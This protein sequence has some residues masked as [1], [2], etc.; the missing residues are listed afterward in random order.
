MPSGTLQAL[1]PSQRKQVNVMSK[2]YR[3]KRQPPVYLVPTQ[4]FPRDA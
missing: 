3:D 1:K 2:F 4:D